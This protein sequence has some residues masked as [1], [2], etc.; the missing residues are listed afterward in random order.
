MKEI[1]H[2]FIR[3][4]T[5]RTRGFT[6]LELIVVVAIFGI[7]SVVSLSGYQGFGLQMRLANTAYDVALTIRQAQLYGASG[8]SLSDVTSGDVAD[9]SYSMNFTNGNSKY[10]MKYI[11]GVGSETIE[12]EYVFSSDYTIGVYQGSVSSVCSSA[13]I[14]YTRPNPEPSLLCDNNTASSPIIIR[15]ENTKTAD[16]RYVNIYNNG[17]ISVT[18]AL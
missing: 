17:Q 1:L 5:T 4:H 2:K 11:I 7:L 6:L 16:V 18:T 14:K 9:L 3:K 13:K 12:K 15:I 10:S 8:K